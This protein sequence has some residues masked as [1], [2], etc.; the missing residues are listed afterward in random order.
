MKKTFRAIIATL[1]IAILTL[2]MGAAAFAASGDLN[3]YDSSDGTLINTFNYGGKSI[4]EG[5]TKISSNGNNMVYYNFE[6]ENTGYYLIDTANDSWVM[7]PET[8]SG[9]NAEGFVNDLFSGNKEDRV[10]LLEKGETVIGIN[11]Y[12]VTEDSITV[13]YLGEKVV[14]FTVD[15]KALTCR[16]IGWD[17]WDCDMEY[18]WVETDSVITFSSGKTFELKDFDFEGTCDSTP[19]TG[20]NTATLEF[21]GVEKDVEFTAYYITDIVESAEISNP[22]DYTTIKTD[23]NG[24]EYWDYINNETLTVTFK[25]GSKFTTTL[26][27]GDA[28]V[29]LPGGR[30][31]YAWVSM[32]ENDNEETVLGIRIAGTLFTE[33]EAEFEEMTL[34]E[35]L[36]VL[37]ENN[38]YAVDWMKFNINM[39]IDYLSDDPEW[40]FK[41]FKWSFEDFIQIFRNISEIISF[42]SIIF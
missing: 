37:N 15:E 24:Y 10:F 32:T 28:F 19:K 2:S 6:V 12:A 5:K 36:G 18:F 40:A 16:I 26:D 39:G 38:M 22:Y 14:D 30:E 25:D 1:L 35:N 27:Y 13:E 31:V 21:C 20:K 9:N 4:E 23:Y 8:V 17:V 34:A 29:V 33:Y 42:Y 11:F 41:Y 3:W 7:I